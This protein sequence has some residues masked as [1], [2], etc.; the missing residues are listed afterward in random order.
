M[1]AQP[2]KGKESAQKSYKEMQEGVKTSAF[3]RKWKTTQLGLGWIF[4]QKNKTIMSTLVGK[5][6]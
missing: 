6:K 5:S 4:G 3:K 2:L 1:N